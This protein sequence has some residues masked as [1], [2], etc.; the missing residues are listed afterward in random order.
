M[1]DTKTCSECLGE[2][3]DGA[4]RCMHCGH[5]QRRSTPWILAALAVVAG[6]ALGGWLY[7]RQQDQGEKKACEQIAQIMDEPARC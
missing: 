5:D 4:R 7:Q 3:P 1:A 2:I 6:L